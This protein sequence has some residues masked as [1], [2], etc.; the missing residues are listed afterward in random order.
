MEFKVMHL[1][2]SFSWSVMGQHWARGGSSQQQAPEPLG[3]SQSALSP[4]S[5]IKKLVM[6]QTS[7]QLKS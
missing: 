1:L 5:L 4:Q 3:L 2:T 7:A 6:P